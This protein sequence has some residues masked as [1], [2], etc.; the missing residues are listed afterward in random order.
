[1]TGIVTI[2]D[3]FLMFKG[4]G[5]FPQLMMHGL[6]GFPLHGLEGGGDVVVLGLVVAVVHGHDAFVLVSEGNDV[7]PEI[8]SL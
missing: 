1:M 8:I 4:V 7:M 2:L 6:V 3:S 5:P